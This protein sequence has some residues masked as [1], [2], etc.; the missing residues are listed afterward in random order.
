VWLAAVRPI[1]HPV[2]QV[3]RSSLGSALNAPRLDGGETPGAASTSIGVYDR[4]RPQAL[5]RRGVQPKVK[6]PAI[7]GGG[8]TVG[9]P[10]IDHHIRPRRGTEGLAQTFVMLGRVTGNDDQD[11]LVPVLPHLGHIHH[12]DELVHGGVDG[13]HIPGLGGKDLD[14]LGPNA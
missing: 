7:I 1:F 9:A 11:R 14:L 10:S 8:N 6:A 12:P 13:A 5:R 4:P 3:Q 2:F